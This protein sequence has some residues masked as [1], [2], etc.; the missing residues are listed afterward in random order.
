MC[1]VTAEFMDLVLKS[2][3]S[4]GDNYFE[5]GDKPSIYGD[6]LSFSGDTLCS[7]EILELLFTIFFCNGV[8]DDW[9][10]LTIV[11]KY[12]LEKLE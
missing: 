2:F 3:V 12:S 1:S 11:L 10:V 9:T 4:S 7:P 6:N 8:F 5:P